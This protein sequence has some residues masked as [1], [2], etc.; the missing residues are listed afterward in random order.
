MLHQVPGVQ[1]RPAIEAIAG[2]PAIKSATLTLTV[3]Y[4]SVTYHSPDYLNIRS[5]VLGYF[6]SS[7]FSPSGET[8]YHSAPKP[9]ISWP[10]VSPALSSRAK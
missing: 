1:N 7:T 9:S 3:D 6:S 8:K 5:D 10:L 2:A 4:E